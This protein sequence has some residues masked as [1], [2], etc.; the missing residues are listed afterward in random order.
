M[1]YETRR[2]LYG[3]LTLGS[4]VSTVSHM[5]WS[6]FRDTD[7]HTRFHF[8][9]AELSGQW[10]GPY[11]AYRHGRPQ[12]W[13]GS[14][15]KQLIDVATALEMCIG[16]TTIGTIIWGAITLL[17]L[18]HR[19]SVKVKQ[20]KEIAESIEDAR[21]WASDM[22]PINGGINQNHYEKINMRNLNQQYESIKN[23][24]VQVR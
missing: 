2:K 15:N 19:K 1:Q 20:K 17:L 22:S 5:C 16:C 11:T 23:M 12:T 14:A 10:H 4:Q 7:Y 18:T 21:I 24:Q 6:L 3:S 9:H 8:D 13:T